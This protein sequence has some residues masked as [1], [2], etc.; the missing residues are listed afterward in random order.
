MI[1][2]IKAF[3]KEYIRPRI[4]PKSQYDCM[5]QIDCTFV[6]LKK[7]VVVLCGSSRTGKS[8]L[9]NILAAKPLIGKDNNY[10]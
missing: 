8:T 9:S 1:S 3:K 6:G 2:V 7:N 5:L 4:E 10:G